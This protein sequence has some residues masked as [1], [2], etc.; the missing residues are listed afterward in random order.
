MALLSFVVLV[1]LSLQPASGERKVRLFGSSSTSST[2]SY[3]EYPGPNSSVTDLWLSPLQ[4]NGSLLGPLG[5]NDSHASSPPWYVAQWNN[6]SPINPN[7]AVHGCDQ[8]ELACPCALAGVLP[9]RW[10]VANGNTRVCFYY[11]NPGSSQPPIIELAQSGGTNLPCGAEFDLFVSPMDGNYPHETQNVNIN[12]PSL[13]ALSALMFSFN[14]SLSYSAVQ[15]RCGRNPQCGPQVDYSY[16]V[17]AIVL[18][19]SRAK[20]HPGPPQTLFYQ[21]LLYD[22][23]YNQGEC[24]INPCKPFR[25]W[26]FPTNPFGVSDFVASYPGAS[27][28]PL[29]LHPIRFVRYDL[30]VLPFLHSAISDTSLGIDGNAEDWSVSGVYVG[31]GLDGDAQLTLLVNDIDLVGIMS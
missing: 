26:F 18:T 5:A 28:L 15:E 25:N 20:N 23:R 8:G 29:S 31:T 9:V 10:W 30:N 7:A 24:P 1:V 27:C 6:P 4:Y 16:V 13:A 22:S 2:S 21:V 14:V 11:T 3:L 17:A 12:A 19:T